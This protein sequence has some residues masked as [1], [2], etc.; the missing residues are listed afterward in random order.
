MAMTDPFTPGTRH[1][2]K[3]AASIMLAALL[4]APIA[5]AAPLSAVARIGREMFS[6][7]ALSAS[8]K[9]S[10]ASCHDPAH[11]YGPANDLAVQFGGARKHASGLR[12]V[13]TLTYKLWTPAF[14]IGP[15]DP[16]SEANEA[17]PQDAA[18]GRDGGQGVRAR[19]TQRIAPKQAGRPAMVPQ[20]GMFW[21]GR[22]DTLQDQAQ[23]VLTSPFEMGP[24]DKDAL[25]QRIAPRYGARLEQLFGPAV[26]SDPDLLVSEAEFALARYQSESSSF[27]PFTSKWDAVLAGRAQLTPEEARG[28]AVFEDP[29]RGNC[30]DCHPDRPARNGSPP[31]FTDFQYEALGVPRNHAIPA[32]SDSHYVDLGLCGPLRHDSVAKQPENCGMFKTPTLRNAATRLTFFHNGVL[33][34]LDQVLDFY[35]NRDAD[36][37]RFYPSGQPA[38]LPGSAARNIDH[39]D[40]PFV[41]KH[42]GKPTLSDSEI[43]ALKAY[44]ETLTDGW[45]GVAPATAQAVQRHG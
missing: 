10:C 39:I 22:A 42:P 17:T 7:P 43:K 11:H 29:K 8:G 32:N 26:A 12:A 37:A 20:G 24:Q 33:H 34:S 6:D 35:A 18:T 31:L 23:G 16:T 19:A 25:A 40:A 4:I 36:P 28:L 38:D 13:P 41:V 2:A 1:S 44:L 9:L 3:G 30:A 15:E 45:D 14:S 27:H 5:Q 21:D